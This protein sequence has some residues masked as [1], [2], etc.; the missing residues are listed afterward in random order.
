MTNDYI[1]LQSIK[2]IESYKMD[3]AITAL[4]GI[5]KHS[6]YFKISVHSADQACQN[7]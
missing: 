7:I 5:L 1:K 3:L 4:L 6:S 2:A